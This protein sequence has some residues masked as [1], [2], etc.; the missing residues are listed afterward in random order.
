M[1]FDEFKELDDKSQKIN[2]FAEIRGVRRQQ[3]TIRKNQEELKKTLPGEVAA[4]IMKGLPCKGILPGSP[5]PPGDP[6]A[7]LDPIRVKAITYILIS[8]LGL[9]VVLGAAYK[10]FRTPVPLPANQQ[11][12]GGG[13]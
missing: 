1:K 4:V 5:C 9:G 8:L 10:E 11:A 13:S 12:L 2:L 7:P 3:R 6:V